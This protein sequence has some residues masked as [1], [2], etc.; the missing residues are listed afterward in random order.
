MKPNEQTVGETR[1]FAWDGFSFKV[2]AD[3][4]L[5]HYSFRRSVSS[6]QMED[7]NA[8]RLEMEWVRPEKT[9][10]RKELQKRCAKAAGEMEEAGAEASAMGALPEGWTAAMYSMPDGKHLL[11][12]YRLVPESMFFCLIKLHF[13]AASRREPPRMARMIAS[14]FQLHEN[15]PVPWEIYDISLQMNREFR[16]VNTSLQAGRK[17]LAF[18][19]RLRRFYIWFFSLADT[20][21]KTKPME[22]WCAEFINGF[23]GIRGPIFIPGEKKGELRSRF[24][25]RYPFGH[26]EELFRGCLRYHAR[27]LHMPEKNH[28][29]LYVFNYRKQEDLAMIAGVPQIGREAADD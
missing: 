8:L 13:P 29:I 28:I 7:D 1:R 5:S 16:L 20:I 21:L 17:M 14:D 9:I 23:K 15:G 26:F 4:N 25:F 24:S 3:W 10:D 12:A 22:D 19:W 2:P 6:L 18:E 11:T 27:C